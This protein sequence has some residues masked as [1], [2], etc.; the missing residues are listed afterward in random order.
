[1][2]QQIRHDVVDQSQSMGDSSPVDVNANQTYLTTAGDGKP[3]FA[4]QNSEP[5]ESLDS[6]VH[7]ISPHNLYAVSSEPL[8]NGTILH[9]LQ[10]S[11][12]VRVGLFRTYMTRA[13]NL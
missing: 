12:L 1:M 7:E 11:E 9:E 10:S 5:N 6:Q 2:A 8:P 3:I 4:P 13:H